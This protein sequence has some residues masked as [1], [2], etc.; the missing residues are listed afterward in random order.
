MQETR[1]CAELGTVPADAVFLC[2]DTVM[3]ANLDQ[4][5]LWASEYF[6]PPR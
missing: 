2:N 4:K 1:C 3:N 6:S 5:W